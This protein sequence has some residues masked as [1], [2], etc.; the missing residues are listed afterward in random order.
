[1][2]SQGLCFFYFKKNI[3]GKFEK[4]VKKKLKL[5]CIDTFELKQEDKQILNLVFKSLLHFKEKS[6]PQTT[7]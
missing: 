7:E 3:R 6:E 1:M 4:V 5:L 2:S